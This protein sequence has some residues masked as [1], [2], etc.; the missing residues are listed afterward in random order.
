MHLSFGISY[1]RLMSDFSR[2]V[3]SLTAIF[4]GS[5]STS[6]SSSDSTS[7][8]AGSWEKLGFWVRNYRK[9]NFQ[10]K[11]QGGFA[12]NVMKIAKTT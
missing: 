1:L 11:K 5:S 8:D 3:S 2:A 6:E 10:V 9:I 12:K 7:S 4:G